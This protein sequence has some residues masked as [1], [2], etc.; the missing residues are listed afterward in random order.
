[1][2]SVFPK[3]ERMFPEESRPKVDYLNPATGEVLSGRNVQG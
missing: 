3:P 2:I 1:M